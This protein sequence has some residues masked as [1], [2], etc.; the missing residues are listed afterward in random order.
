MHEVQ[1]HIQ[2][3]KL[4]EGRVDTNID[5]N[6]QVD[7]LA[8]SGCKLDHTNAVAPY[9]HACPWLGIRGTRSCG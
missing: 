5:G 7:T 3:T 4:H 2:T 6:K 8:K 9:E 1:S